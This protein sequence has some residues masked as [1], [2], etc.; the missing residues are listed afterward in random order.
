VKSRQGLRITCTGKLSERLMENNRG[1]MRRAL[2]SGTVSGLAT[3]GIAS[4]AGKRENDSYAAPLNATSHIVWGEE[5]VYHDRP[6]LKYTLTGFLL[7]HASTI[8]WASFYEKL[9]GRHVAKQRLRTLPFTVSP[10]SVSL[11]KPVYGGAAVA[12]AAYIIDYH[13]IPKRF[14]P[15]FEKRVSEK[16]LT[17]IFAALAIGLAVRDV[18]DAAVEF[19]KHH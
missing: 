14:T 19:H 11:V 13:L 1:I 7:N 16:S 2:I 12:V 5:A 4:L 6:S 8:F 9:F 10:G 15:G 3:A 18:I 17:A